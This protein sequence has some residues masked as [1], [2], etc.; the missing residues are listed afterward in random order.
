MGQSER[1]GGINGINKVHKLN[2]LSGEGRVGFDG[3]GGIQP[4]LG[5]Q[6]VLY[7]RLQVFGLIHAGGKIYVNRHVFPVNIVD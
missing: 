7:S 5:F 6:D 3:R 1:F 2:R 4:G